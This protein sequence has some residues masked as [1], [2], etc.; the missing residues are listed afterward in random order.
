MSFNEASGSF[1]ELDPV[2]S[3]LAFSAEIV[4]PKVSIDGAPEMVLPGW[5]PARIPV[6]PGPHRVE[7]WMTWGINKNYGRNALDVQVPA[8]GI[9]VSWK[10]PGTAFSKGKMSVSPPG[11]EPV[12]VVAA[13]WTAGV[14][15]ANPAAWHPDPTGRHQYRWWDGTT[16]SPN[17]SDDG[18]ASEDPV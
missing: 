8:E 18:V 16:W 3:K 2:H 7:F 4:K 1:I 14:G 6:A 13:S 9:R 10:T 15:G 5:R 12:D 17:V 11:A